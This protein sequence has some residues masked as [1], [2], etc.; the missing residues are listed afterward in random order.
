M[1]INQA[2]D[3][4]FALARKNQI[5]YLNIDG[6]NLYAQRS[7]LDKIEKLR[8]QYELTSIISDELSPLIKT[9]E[10]P[11][12]KGGKFSKPSDF[13]YS[14]NLETFIYKNPSECNANDGYN[15]WAEVKRIT[16]DRKNYYLNS[17]IVPPDNFY[18]VAVDFG[19]SFDVYPK[20]GGMTYRLTYISN[21]SSP[22]WVG[23]G[24]PPVYDPVNSVDWMLPE[25]THN[26]LCATILSYIG[27]SIRDAELYQGAT[28]EREKGGMT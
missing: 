28:Y 15:T 13:I 24:S 20:T 6:F 4:I 19:S 3:Y 26:E 1:N 27:L 7:Q 2:K 12:E 10:H 8:L 25:I 21:P 17:T 9:I 14:V 18:P 16:Q 23:V 11:L 5:G 22:V